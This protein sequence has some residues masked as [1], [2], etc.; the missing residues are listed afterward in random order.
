[1]KFNTKKCFILVKILIFTCYI[2]LRLTITRSKTMKIDGITKIYHF[3]T[4]ILCTKL[5]GVL[6]YEFYQ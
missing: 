1:M 3:K 6:K 4:K 2:T 5:N